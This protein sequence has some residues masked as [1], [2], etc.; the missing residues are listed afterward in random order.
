MGTQNYAVQPPC[1]RGVIYS[2]IVT[3]LKLPAL[4]LSVEGIPGLRL[5]FVERELDDG[6]GPRA[7][8]APALHSPSWN[9]G[10]LSAVKPQNP[11]ILSDMERTQAPC[12][13]TESQ[14]V[15]QPQFLHGSAPLNITAH[16]SFPCITPCGKITTR[17]HTAALSL[18][19]LP[20]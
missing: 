8:L 15:A 19:R 4:D 2:A 17:P 7:V 20:P 18:A 14:G 6:D 3:A 5:A 13:V 16:T 12:H 1:W 10:F 9:W 11:A